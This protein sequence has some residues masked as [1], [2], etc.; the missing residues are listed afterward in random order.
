MSW[1]INPHPALSGS[2]YLAANR[3]WFHSLLSLVLAI[4]TLGVSWLL[5]PLFVRQL[6]TR[7]LR[8]QG[9]RQVSP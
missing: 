2:F 1:S 5:Y 9:W 7:H 6:L 8:K 4:C 3:M